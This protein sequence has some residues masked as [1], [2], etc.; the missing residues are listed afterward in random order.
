[1]PHIEEIEEDSE[2]E[3]V[4]E[5]EEEEEEVQQ[6]KDTKKLSKHAAKKAAKKDGKLE[7]PEVDVEEEE[8]EDAK[9]SG[10]LATKKAAKKDGK[11]EKAAPQVPTPAPEPAMPSMK[12]SQI[13]PMLVMLA[14]QK[15]DIVEMGLTRHVEVAYVVAQL[16]CIAFLLF[17][18]Q[19]IREKPDN[20]IK[21]KI[22]A[23]VSM[24]QVTAPASEKTVKEYDLA[25]NR[26]HLKQN[27]M[28]LVILGGIYYKWG[29]V[30]PLLLQLVMTPMSL[31]ESPLVEIYIFGKTVSRPFPAP[32]PFGLPSSPAAAEPE[33]ISD[34]SETEK[35][36]TK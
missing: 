5:E 24:G 23:V 34:V 9:K 33:T 2:V 25:K 3:V 6:E 1:M 27:F 36:K 30:M 4:E 14:L 16:L 11:L 13:V 18:D 12:L 17:I 32:N 10:K 15:Y 28:G 26:E 22:P 20:G 29:S 35:K 31:Y 7:K 19:K 8:E 21:I